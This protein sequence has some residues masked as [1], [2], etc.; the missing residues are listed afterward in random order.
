M[1]IFN[2]YVNIEKI[3]QILNNLQQLDPNE[4]YSV[5]QCECFFTKEETDELVSNFIARY[6][7]KTVFTLEKNG[8]PEQ[9]RVYI[10]L[11]NPNQ[12]NLKHDLYIVKNFGFAKAM[13]NDLFIAWLPAD[14][15][16]YWGVVD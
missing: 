16:D 8:Q 10:A 4:D 13:W 14:M 15:N 2:H 3:N 1:H 7:N 11:A 6:N 12:K 5:L 9:G